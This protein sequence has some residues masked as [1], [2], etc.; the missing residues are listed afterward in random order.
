MRRAR[1][2]LAYPDGRADTSGSAGGGAGSAGSSARPAL[3][4]TEGLCEPAARA[5]A[6]AR[7]GRA[8][9]RSVLG[10]CYRPPP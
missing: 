10:T 3:T 7:G 4:R 5:L 9:A 1:Q 8:I 6:I 2:G